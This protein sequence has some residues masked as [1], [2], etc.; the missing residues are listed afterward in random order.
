M[1]WDVEGTDEFATWFASLDEPTRERVSA[2]V[3]MLEELGPALGHPQSSQIKGSR[4]GRMRE[5]RIQPYRV[6]YAFDPRRTAILLLGGSKA[7][8]DRWY[9][10]H[11]ARADDLYDEH[12][13]T[14]RRE[15]LIDGNDSD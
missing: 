2:T 8:D 10:Q 1:I 15:G 4:H 7:G 6:L 9:E 12:L 11:V 14:I 13:E 5:L 3:T